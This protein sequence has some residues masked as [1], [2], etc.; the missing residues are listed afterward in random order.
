M[1]ITIPLFVGNDYFCESGYV[2]PGNYIPGLLYVFHSDDPLW[3]GDGCI[4]TST[5]CLL[6]NPPYFTKTL[7]APTIDDLE[8]RLCGYFPSSYEDVAAELIELYVK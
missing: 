5:C 3:D 6:N 8:L 7:P 1:K 2:W 4:S